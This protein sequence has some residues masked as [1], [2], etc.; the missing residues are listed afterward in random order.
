MPDVVLLNWGFTQTGGAEVVFT[1]EN[2]MQAITWYY[3]KQ[4]LTTSYHWTVYVIGVVNLSNVFT[5]NMDYKS[6]TI[7]YKLFNL[8]RNLE[9]HRRSF[10]TR[11][12]MSAVSCY[13]PAGN[14]MY[15]I[16]VYRVQV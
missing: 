15:T 1:K 9:W 14:T 16:I 2:I 7:L 4:G 3:E 13:L 8:P 11:R 6:H 10:D 5:T 12:L